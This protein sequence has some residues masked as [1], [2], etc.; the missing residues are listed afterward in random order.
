MLDSRQTLLTVT[1]LRHWRNR[2]VGL[3]PASTESSRDPPD[4]PAA[5]DTPP[6]R[7]IAVSRLIV[8]ETVEL[9]F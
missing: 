7:G 5:P 1:T 4:G 6:D 9:M 3:R 2:L 8:G